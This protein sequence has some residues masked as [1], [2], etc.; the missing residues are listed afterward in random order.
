MQFA[1]KHM[2]LASIIV[3]EINQTQTQ[4]DKVCVS[5]LIF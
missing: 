3:S 2:E 5:P 4:K 1:G